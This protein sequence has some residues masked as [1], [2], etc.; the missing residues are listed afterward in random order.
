MEFIYNITLIKITEEIS[1]NLDSK[2][3]IID[4]LISEKQILNSQLEKITNEIS[5]EKDKFRKLEYEYNQMKTIH[6][7]LKMDISRL[8]NFIKSNKINVSFL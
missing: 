3:R 7:G 6:D 5:K 4:A 8:E 2:N 1:R